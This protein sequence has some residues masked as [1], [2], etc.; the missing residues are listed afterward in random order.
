MKQGRE[1]ICNS[2]AK[3]P[4]SML[5]A[6]RD[7]QGDDRMMCPQGE[8]NLLLLIR[9]FKTLSPLFLSPSCSEHTVYERCLPSTPAHCQVPLNS[10]LFFRG[11]E[12]NTT[13]IG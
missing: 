11:L 13:G 1:H 10:F 5:K 12:L 6:A 2:R 7:S 3:F 4:V 8:Q 9:L